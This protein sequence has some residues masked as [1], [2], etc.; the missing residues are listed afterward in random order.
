MTD[1]DWLLDDI[2]C[3]M[4]T[5]FMKIILDMWTCWLSKQGDWALLG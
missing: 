3:V 1:D 2:G 5:I 4:I